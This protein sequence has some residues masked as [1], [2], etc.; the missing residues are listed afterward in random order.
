MVGLEKY[1]I[2][3]AKN[4]KIKQLE[5]LINE[6]KE[7][8]DMEKVAL[9]EEILQKKKLGKRS[10]TK[11]SNYER[12]IAKIFKDYLGIELHR[13]PLSGGF[14]KS[15][16]RGNDF[17]G[18]IVPLEDNID[19]KLHIE[20]KDHK[21]WKLQEWINQAKED[22]AEDKIPIVV[23]H[24]YNTSEDYVALSLSDFLKIIDKEKV[25]IK[26]T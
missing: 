4:M 14:A 25:V 11:G 20:A 1:I 3:Q 9:L 19:F 22:C 8:D 13:T 7:Y 26:K 16:K 23:F 6:F 5:M 12:K 17:K 18:D 24:K 21:T 15:K 2:E 10:K